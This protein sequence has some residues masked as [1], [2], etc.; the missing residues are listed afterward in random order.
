M[1][2]RTL[3]LLRHAKSDWS[4]DEDDIARPLNKRG[5]RQAPDTG[6]WLQAN[7]ASIDLAVVSPASRART[8]WQLVSAEL[9]VP[10]PT[11]IEDRIY[12]ASTLEL[13]GVVRQL[14]DDV[15][16]A[17]VVGHNPGLEDLAFLLAGHRMSMPTA[18]LAVMAMS[19]PWSAAAHS[20][21]T[22][23]ASGRPPA[24]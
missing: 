7:T 19:G 8:T 5:R 21:A 13:L 4:G 23:T 20:S 11:R 6:R 1:A 2:E 10:P 3:I 24:D 17:V 22:L 14:P 12:A 16:I 15:H 9:D 18:A